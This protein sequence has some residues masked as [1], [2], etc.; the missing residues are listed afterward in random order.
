MPH[1]DTGTG[2][3]RCNR[4]M[5]ALRMVGF[6]QGPELLEDAVTADRDLHEGR[7]VGRAVIVP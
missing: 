1:S 7:V 2:V 5:R 3:T 4:G 6:T